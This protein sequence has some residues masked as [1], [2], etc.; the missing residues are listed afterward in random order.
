MSALGSTPCS[1]SARA[2]VILKPSSK[3]ITSV[4]W[5]A[6]SGVGT[7][8]GRPARRSSEHTGGV[9]EPRGPGPTAVRLMG[10]V[11]EGTAY[12][13]VVQSVGLSQY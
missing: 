8:A 7:A 4:R 1:A 6:S 5:L 10:V 9:R 2:S 12:P 13:R 3:V 11:S